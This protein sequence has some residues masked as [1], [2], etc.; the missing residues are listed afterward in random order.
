MHSSRRRRPQRREGTRLEQVS[1]QVAEH[2]LKP[3][4]VVVL[5]LGAGA[6]EHGP[7]LPL[8]TDQRLA[9]YVATR[10]VQDLNVVVAP[11]LAYHHVPGFTEYRRV[12]VPAAEHR[13]RPDR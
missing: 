10:I 1:W 12:D 13:A 6:S 3:E 7:H 2:Q 8:G 9:E 11:T 4:T 5:P